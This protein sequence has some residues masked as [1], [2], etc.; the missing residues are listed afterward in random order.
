MDSPPDHLRRL[1]ASTDVPCPNC[2]YNLRGLTGD[3]C[4]EC[5]QRLVLRVGL[6]DPQLGKLIGAAAG[7]LTGAGTAGAVR[8]FVTLTLLSDHGSPSRMETV[9]LII[10]PAGTL[11]IE[12]YLAVCLLRLRGRAWFQ[13]LGSSGRASSVVLAWTLTLVIGLVW[14]L[15]VRSCL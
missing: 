6:A 4:P 5:N 14:F 12:G 9:L 11:M 3:A 13:R 2:R 8:F 15:L 1:L 10:A 7:L